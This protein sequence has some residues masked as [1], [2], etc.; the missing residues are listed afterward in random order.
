MP[1][2]RGLFCVQNTEISDTGLNSRE[3]QQ[4]AAT[5]TAR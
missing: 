3:R 5:V 4:S 1:V 2:I